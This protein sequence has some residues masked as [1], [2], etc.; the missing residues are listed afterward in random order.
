MMTNKSGPVEY[1]ISPLA[2][3]YLPINSLEPI[4]CECYTEHISTHSGNE[5]DQEQE[6]RR[7]APIVHLRLC[8]TIGVSAVVVE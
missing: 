6:I 2:Y 5:L 7:L 3:A 8:Q 4:H 1:P